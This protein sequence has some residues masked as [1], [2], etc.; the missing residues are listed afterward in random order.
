MDNSFCPWAH[1]NPRKFV[2]KGKNI[3]DSVIKMRF[4]KIKNCIKNI[5][6]F[7]YIP[8]AQDIIEGYFLSD[9]GEYRFIVLQGN[10]RLAVIKALNSKNPLKFNYIPVKFASSRLKFKIASKGNIN[11]WPAVKNGIIN[12]SDAR[13]IIDSYF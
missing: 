6:E 13:E 9:G 3:D 2:I 7:G 4:Q 11:S 5:V 12:I 8:T 1:E 10:H